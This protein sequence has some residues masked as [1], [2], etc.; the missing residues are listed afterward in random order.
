MI[1]LKLFGWVV[2]VVLL[3]IF[4]V[5]PVVTVVLLHLGAKKS[6]TEKNN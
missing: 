1:V 2:L 4:V 6:V 3:I 5:I